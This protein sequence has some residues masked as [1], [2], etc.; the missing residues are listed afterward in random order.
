MEPL[1]R[2]LP[3]IIGVAS[4]GRRASYLGTMDTSLSLRLWNRFTP[5]GARLVQPPPPV[6]SISTPSYSLL[7]RA[8]DRSCVIHSLFYYYYYYLSLFIAYRA[9]APGLA[10]L[11]GSLS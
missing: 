4:R 10:M 6:L 1:L 7:V 2:L 3:S 11:D 5:T 8:E 9:D